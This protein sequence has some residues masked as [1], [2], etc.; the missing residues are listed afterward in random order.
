MFE[1]S[2]EQDWL[3]AEREWLV[4]RALTVDRAGH[5][6]PFWLYDDTIE[7]RAYKKYTD[8]IGETK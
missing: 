4:Q 2:A 6:P 8:R 7:R 3:E 5:L 1:G